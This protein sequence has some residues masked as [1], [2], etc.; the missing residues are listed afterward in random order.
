[1]STRWEYC[2]VRHWIPDLH[3]TIRAVYY[4]HEDSVIGWDPNPVTLL[5]EDPTALRKALTATRQA[6]ARPV[7]DAGEG[8]DNISFG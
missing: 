8:R 6:L 2:V 1:M 3:Y 4:D 7:L 5:G